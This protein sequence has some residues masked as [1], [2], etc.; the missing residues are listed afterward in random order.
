MLHHFHTPVDNVQAFHLSGV[1]FPIEIFYAIPPVTVLSALQE[2][3][4]VFSTRFLARWGEWG[5]VNNEC[6]RLLVFFGVEGGEEAMVIEL[7]S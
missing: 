2:G 7:F 3:I 5:L 1:E 4:A 6:K